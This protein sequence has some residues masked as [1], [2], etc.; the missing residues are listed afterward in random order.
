L[1]KSFFVFINLLLLFTA[2]AQ[3]NLYYTWVNGSDIFLQNANYGAKGVESSS[4]IPGARENSVSWVDKD[5]SLWLF[6]GNGYNSSGKGYL[7]DLWKYSI[8]INQWTWIAGT[9]SL[10]NTGNY[11][12]K[13]ISSSTVHPCSRQNAVTWTD[14][15][16]L[17]W[18]FGGQKSQ[19]SFL[20]DLWNYNTFTNEWT[21][22]T[23]SNSANQKSSY[24]TKGIA[25]ATN[26]PGA[27]FGAMTWIDTINNELWLLGGQ[28]YTTTTQRINDLWKY[29]IANNAWTWVG[30]DSAANAFGIYG[31]KGVTSSSIAPGARQASVTWRDGDNNFWLFGGD[32]YPA[33]G[34]MGYLNDLWKYNPT[35]NEWT[36]VN[37][38]NT[39]S[40][41]ASYGNKGITSIN[42]IPG[43]RQ[44]SISWSD[45][46]NNLWL[47]GGWGFVGPAFGRLND[48]W[49][50]TTSNNEWTWMG[51]AN[52]TDQKGTYENKGTSSTTATPG[53]R[54][55]SVS[56]TDKNG[57]M[58]LF[59][60]NGYDNLDSLGVMNDLWKIS[61]DESSEI[62]SNNEL[63]LINIYPNPSSDNIIISVNDNNKHSYVLSS[64]SGL[65]IRNGIFANMERV[66]LSDLSKGIYLLKVDEKYVF[67]V[68]CE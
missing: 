6:S 21:W 38:S 23:G 46:E 62:Y 12:A 22:V 45:K 9:S 58:W 63:A 24:G 27:R 47:F 18:L 53:A 61:F 28:Q 51:G 49:K 7:N 19:N 32:G 64:I 15:A 59:G 4:N 20:N 34:G 26:T 11:S 17:L 29:S 14:T 16:G 30:G 2:V 66:H 54:R 67:K 37:G 31:T 36:W 65:H 35:S 44:M 1:K 33:S 3:N 13:G 39:I 55:M 40:Q 8:S 60:G 50:Y 42:N 43:A 5:N 52:T 25:S 68:L 41:V 56:W 10:G 48:L 57:N